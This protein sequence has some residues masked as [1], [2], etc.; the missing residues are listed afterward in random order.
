MTNQAAPTPSIFAEPR[1]LTSGANRALT[2]WQA[3]VCSMLQE[4]WQGLLGTDLTITPGKS[5]SSTAI[6]VINNRA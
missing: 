5:D 3:T 2:S 1:R 6:K 4:N